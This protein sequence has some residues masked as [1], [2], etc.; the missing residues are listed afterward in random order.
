MFE[1]R[2]V[3]DRDAWNALV[4]DLPGADLRQSWSWGEIR[5]RQGWRVAR[6]AAHRDGECVAA[7]AAFW[8]RLPGLGVVAY[9]PRGPLLRDAERGWAALRPLLEAAARVTGAAFVRLS[10]GVPQERFDVAAR[11]RGLGLTGLPDFWTLWNSPRNVM[12]LSLAGAERDVLA[13]MA[14][15]RRQHVSTA[16]RKGL[17]AI[18]SDDDAAMARF[19]AMVTAH[20]QRGRYPVRGAG[21]FEALRQAFAP[22]AAFALVEGRVEGEVCAALLGVRFGAVAYALSA[23]SSPRARGT[24][25][26]DLVHW[27][28]IRWA[29][30]AGCEAVDFG[31][32][33]TRVAPAPTDPAGGI[34]R[35][36]VEIGCEPR[37]CLPYHDWV[38]DAGRHRIVRALEGAAARR[39]RAWLD[40]LPASLRLRLAQRVA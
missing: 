3:A 2:T 16:A 11:R 10:P 7:L 8:R 13:R 9:A 27:E 29:H 18:R 4:L 35:F 1:I 24:A 36:K 15:K 33:G 34:Y 12:R 22:A 14:R 31:S 19:G 26:G 30:A 21:Y 39:A 17:E 32:S 6:L 37:L 38:V 20:A 5:A 23:P 40:R 25:I 28:W